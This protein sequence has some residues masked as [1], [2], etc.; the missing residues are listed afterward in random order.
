MR[1]ETGDATLLGQSGQ[2]AWR[3]SRWQA[4]PTRHIFQILKQNQKIVF[5]ARKIDIN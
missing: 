3:H 2:A 5:R 1:A 4:G